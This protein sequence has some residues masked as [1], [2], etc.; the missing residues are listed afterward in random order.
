MQSISASNYRKACKEFIL[1]ALKRPQMFFASLEEFQSVLRG[2]ETAFGQMTQMH[3]TEMLHDQF[4]NWLFDRFGLSC[5]GGWAYA[6]EQQCKETG[7]DSVRK[8]GVYITAF[9]E[10]WD[11]DNLRLVKSQT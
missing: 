6:I 9:F 11:D 4:S 7:D 2:H 10:S 3:R 1:S 5:S 8:F